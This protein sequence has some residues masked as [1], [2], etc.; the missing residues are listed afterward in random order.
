LA[1]NLF[2]QSVSLSGL[3]NSGVFAQ[4]N[5]GNDIAISV[6][7]SNLSLNNPNFFISGLTAALFAD[8][9]AL[10]VKQSQAELPL[11]TLNQVT[12]VNNNASAAASATA[13]TPNGLPIQ[14]AFLYKPEPI[15]VRDVSAPA[16]QN[17]LVLQPPSSG[18]LRFPVPDKTV[19]DLINISGN[20]FTGSMTAG[21]TPGAVK[22]LLLP[23]NSTVEATLVSGEPLPDGVR[24]NPSNKTFYIEK[25]SD[26]NLPIEVKLTLKNQSQTL[27]EKVILVTK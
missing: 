17:I 27:A 21:A 5:P 19:Q 3:I 20:G 4:A 12:A 13:V 8:I 2:G 11:M 25:L 9:N 1:G 23:E 10:P 22:L 16:T 15:Y 6:A 18:S 24:F 26:V 7:L 14:P